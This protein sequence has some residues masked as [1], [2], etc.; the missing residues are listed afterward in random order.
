[1]RWSTAPVALAGAL[2]VGA[3]LFAIQN[4]SATDRSVPH[5][6]APS[7]ELVAQGEQLYL[8]GC[9]SCHGAGGV[10][11]SRAPTLIGV[12]A[13]SASFYLTTGR[14]PAA[15]GEPFQPPRKQPAYPPD[16]ID[17]LV[18]YVASLGPGPAIPSVDV[19]DADLANGGVLYRANCAACHQ[20]AGAGGA[21]SYGHSAPRLH[22]A[23]PTQVVEAMRIGPGQMPVFNETTFNDEAAEDVAAYVQYLRDPD[24]RG[25]AAL[26]GNGPVPEGA[27]S[28][29]AGLGGVVAVSVWIV[30]RHRRRRGAHT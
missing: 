18:A 10:G 26:G 21:L 5:Q 15:Q 4:A 8:T 28:L 24:N 29:V 25:G 16:Q 27:V 13:A 17:A 1:V 30:G 9:S 11:T 7:P 22:D 3:G 23:T 12:G 6:A 20:A 2:A 19:A 14:M